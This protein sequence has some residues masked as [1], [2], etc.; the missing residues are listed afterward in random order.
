[1]TLIGILG[2]MGPLATVDFMAKVVQLTGATCDQQHLPM[3]VANLPHVADRSRAILGDGEDCLDGL[4][5]GIDLLN[6]NGV[7]LITIPC[8]SAHHWYAQMLARSEA[9][10]LHIADACVA[11]VPVSARRVAVLGTG[12][13]L[14]S[15][16][17]QAALAARGIE[18]VVPDADMQQRIAACIHEVKAGALEQAAGHLAAVLDKLSAQ[19]VHAA[20][21][22]CTEIPL[23]AQHL[24]DPPLTLI[25][26]SLELARA[27]V[28]FAVARGWNRPQ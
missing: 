2:G 26:S 20:V 11:A 22:G 24:S 23:A 21:M 19:D 6:R 27:T 5:E 14:M 18:P 13:T 9:P 16:F 8:N 4:L 10:V 17:Y 25:D 7:G 1:M 28:S 15:G 12:G 3:L